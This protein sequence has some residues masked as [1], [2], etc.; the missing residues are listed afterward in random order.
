MIDAHDRA[1]PGKPRSLLLKG[2][3]QPFVRLTPTV[4]PAE[5]NAR[6]GASDRRDGMA[7]HRLISRVSEVKTLTGPSTTHEV[8]ELAA[9]LFAEASNFAPAIEAIRRSAQVIIRRGARWLQFRPVVIESGPGAGKTRFAH[10]LAA[11]SGLQLVYLDCAAM[12]NMSPI[13]SQDATWSG[14]RQSE[15]IEAL[16]NSSSANLIV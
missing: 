3:N 10:R 7:V 12:T 4:D 6:R 2:F 13:L 11:L 15:I 14:A 16:A 9:A 8:D 5:Q 1:I